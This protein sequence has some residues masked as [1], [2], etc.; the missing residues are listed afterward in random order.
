MAERI[1]PFAVARTRVLETRLL[2]HQQLNQMA[3]AKN[4]EEV[5][6][7]L[8]EAG[9]DTDLAET[10]YDYEQVLANEQAKTSALM[11]ELIPD[12]KFMDL[13]LYKNDYHNAKVLIKSQISGVDGEA[14]LTDSGAIPLEK[15]KAALE[16]HSYSS[17]P[18]ILGKA[19]Q[20]AFDTYASLQDGQVIDLILDKACFVAM[21]ETA[22]ERGLPFVVDYVARLSDVTNLK[23]FYRM[24]QMKKPVDA[25]KAAFVPGGTMS[26]ESFVSAYGHDQFWNAFKG[27]AYGTLC[28]TGMQTSFT[29]FERLCDNFMMESVKAAKYVALTVEPLVAYQY[30]RESEIKT[31]RI[32]MTGKLNQIAPETIKE[33]LRDAYV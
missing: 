31:V 23:T 28:E 16:D 30:A 10:V 6:R 33:R 29:E 7:V 21:G 14:Y 12:E 13:F 1:Y 18:A 8:R 27:S 26:V 5:M 25:F 22:Q 11:K 9:Y 19:I 3:E 20:E 17:L 15:L 4:A 32:I 2:T 24:K